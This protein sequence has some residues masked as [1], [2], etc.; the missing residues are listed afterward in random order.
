MDLFNY[1]SSPFIPG[2]DI[3]N[4]MAFASP[5]TLV[6]NNANRKKLI[7]QRSKNR[8]KP[9][10]QSSKVNNYILNKFEKFGRFLGGIPSQEEVEQIR[11]NNPQMDIF[12]TDTQLKNEGKVRDK[13]GNVIDSITGVITESGNK[14]GTF[15][16]KE[17]LNDVGKKVKTDLSGVVV[18]TPSSN[19]YNLF[20][21]TEGSKED[22]DYEKMTEY[23]KGVIGEVDKVAQRARERDFF[24]EGIRSFA[25]APLIGA[26]ANLEAAKNIAD[27]TALNMGAMAAQNRALE[28]NPTKQKIAGKYFR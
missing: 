7:E 28:T 2:L 6:A 21:L 10:E 16:L 5:E 23:A 1:S 4:M 18:D 8:K 24:R 14:Q 11:K 26:Q 12:K 25:N 13:Q 3:G 22:I 20:D 17:H 9:I 27:L 19:Y 15:S